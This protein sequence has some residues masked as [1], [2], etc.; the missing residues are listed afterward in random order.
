[1]RMGRVNPMRTRVGL[2]ALFI[3][4]AVLECLPAARERAKVC[5]TLLV[6][7]PAIAHSGLG[8]YSP[9]QIRHAY[10]FD[11]VAAQGTGQVIAIVDA[12]GS[13]T[14][15]GDFQTFCNH[16][17]LPFSS[18]TLTV[19]FSGAQPTSSDGGWG[20]E[21]TMDS[22]W[23]H[24]IA[25]Q[26]KI[27]LV[28]TP[29]ASLGDL[30]AGVDFA[31]NYRDPATGQTPL[32]VSM[33][34]GT[35]EFSGETSFDSH[36]SDQRVSY[37]AATGDNGAGA[38]WPAASPF[39]IG[40]GG[41]TLNLNPLGS[42]ASETGW[43][44]SGGGKS[45]FETEPGF[46]HNVQSSGMRET[47]DVS[48]DADPN[49]GFAVFD[50]TAFNGI[51]GWSI[52]GGTSAGAPQWAA[53]AAI[54]NSQRSTPL[55][56]IPWALYAAPYGS[57]FRDVTSGS[58]GTNTAG[59][60]YDE[61]TGLGSP[62]AAGLASSLDG[63]GPPPPPPPPPPPAPPAPAPTA[64]LPPPGSP[65]PG[66]TPSGFTGT[67]GGGGGSSCALSSGVSSATGLPVL[68]LVFALVALRKRTLSH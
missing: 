28:I 7:R 11:T 54:V 29:T 36:F 25:P 32:Q 56:G 1:M 57:S 60:G 37:F 8:G 39:V 22:E 24:A 62:L 26:A 9:T 43:S 13:P 4:V 10:G 41:T 51:S 65:P 47:P 63:A 18:S 12:F 44:Q 52:G 17:G 68:A 50:S 16:F 35:P 49:T 6:A 2:A 59:T 20:Y 23:A 46:Q 34:W 64:P 3:G 15:Q 58:N 31:T 61:V 42:V 5:P 27:L 45:A 67:G 30:L 48:Y 19:A 33:S 53:L 21:A 38:F 55:S 40:I 66:P 14:I